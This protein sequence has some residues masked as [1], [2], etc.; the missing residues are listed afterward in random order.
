MTSRERW[1]AAINMQ[2]VD[3]LPFWPKVFN[4]YIKNQK[5]PFNTFTVNELYEY[6][7]CDPQVNL[8]DSIKRT[9]KHSSLEK[10]GTNSERCIVYQTKHG[11]CVQ[12]FR[13]DEVTDTDHPMEFPIKNREDIRIMTEWY[14]DSILSV[15]DKIAEEQ[16]LIIKQLGENGVTAYF[17]GESPLMYFL[18]YLAGVENAHYLLYDYPYEVEE[19]FDAMHRELVKRTELACQKCKADLLYFAEN[20]STTLISPSQYEKYCFSHIEDYARIINGYGRNMVL[21]MCGHLKDLL[22][23]LSK[24]AAKAFEA[25][26]SP[27]VGNTTLLDGRNICTDKCLIGGTNAI[28]WTMSADDIINQIEY[29]L[30]VLPHHRGIIVTSSGVMPPMCSPDTIKTVCEWVKN[31]KVVV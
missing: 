25:F 28:L 26:T 4:G 9:G 11:S 23:Q 18:E 2:P 16:E 17:I 30:N 19:L 5:P 13:Y 20:T 14:R 29:D 12:S 6:V 8:P 21:H 10:H 7:G 22:P 3:R 31:Y 24:V 1:L 27:T 15:D